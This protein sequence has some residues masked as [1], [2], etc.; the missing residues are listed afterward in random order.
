MTEFI[1]AMGTPF[2]MRA[3]DRHRRPLKSSEVSR[4]LPDGPVICRWEWRRPVRKRWQSQRLPRQSLI[5][6]WADCPAGYS[7]PT[8]S[9]SQ[10][11]ASCCHPLP[12]ECRS[13]DDK[14][15]WWPVRRIGY[16]RSE[17]LEVYR[18]IPS[19]YRDLPRFFFAKHLY[20]C[21]SEDHWHYIQEVSW[22]AVCF[23]SIK[24]NGNILQFLNMTYSCHVFGVIMTVRWW[25]EMRW[26][27][28]ARGNTHR[29]I[30]DIERMRR[31]YREEE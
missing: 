23:S 20:R 25:E 3:S 29:D 16:S 8:R 10:G 17:P 28:G 31:K 9:Q 2:L 15:S 30:G 6:R 5:Q 12:A 11:K 22:S 14:P 21:I 27:C 19:G 18:A 4:R 24:T 7:A 26:A 1:H 13:R